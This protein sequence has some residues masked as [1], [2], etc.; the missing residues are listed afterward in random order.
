MVEPRRKHGVFDPR[1]PVLSVPV[2]PAWVVDI[3]QGLDWTEFVTRFFAGR[4]RH[5][6]ESLAAYGAYRSASPNDV[7]TGDNGNESR[8]GAL[9]GPVATPQLIPTRGRIT[10]ANKSKNATQ[11]RPKSIKEPD[12]QPMVSLKTKKAKKTS[13]G[14]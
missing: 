8:R 9:W 4:G 1:Y 13:R 11:S 3:D 12:R 10:M 6:I 7:P 5:D 14:K 2:A